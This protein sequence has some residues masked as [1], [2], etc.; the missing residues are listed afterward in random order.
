MGCVRMRD[1]ILPLLAAWYSSGPGKRLIR[2]TSEGSRRRKGCCGH[3][4]RHGLFMRRRVHQHSVLVLC[5]VA[6]GLCCIS[7]CGG[8]Q[9][10]EILVLHAASLSSALRDMAAAFEAENP[11]TRV[12]RETVG[13]KAGVRK[14]TDLGRRCD[15]FVSADSKLIES[16]LIPS[17]ASWSISFAGNALCLAYRD[18][19]S[20]SEDITAENWLEVLAEEG[21]R[22]ARCDPNSAPCGYRTIHALMLAEEMYGHAGIA[23]IIVGKS[24]RHLRPKESDLLALLETGSVDYAMVYRSTAIQQGF[25]F[26]ELPK[27]INL[28][29]AKLW[30]LYSRVK[31]EV[32]G[33]HPDDLVMEVGRP[34]TY[35]VTIPKNA[36]HAAAAQNFAAFMLDPDRGTAIIERH[37]LMPA[38]STTRT[39]SALPEALK[40]YAVPV[41]LDG[42]G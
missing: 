8:A 29:D 5:A 25:R 17:H 22:F 21:V 15:V 39:Y 41:R 33:P 32:A 40:V 28:S 3:Y 16:L 10:D 36:P 35:G 7:G 42:E 6:A 24:A 30:E 18:G 1:R 9:D 37:G 38:P 19:S 26:V 27:E 20:R 12:V 14:L 11:G 34:I 13:S 4:F 31:V 2:L 23:D